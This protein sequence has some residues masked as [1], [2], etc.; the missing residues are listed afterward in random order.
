VLRAPGINCERETA[1]AFTRH[2]ASA[3]LLHVKRLLAEPDALDGFRIL[4]VPGGFAYGDH[5]AAGRI[6]AHELRT[7]LG[8]RL[9]RFVER[10]GLA[11]GICNGFQALAK[12]GL[13][14]RTTGPAALQEISLMHNDSDHYECRWV[15]L[16]CEASRCVFLTPGAVLEVPSAH[17]EGKYVPA[18]PELHA[19]LAA[20][21][22]VA[23]RY[24][25]AT[26]PARYPANPNGSLDD[27]A[28]ITDVTGRVL[29]LMPHPDRAFLPHHHPRWPREGLARPGDGNEI[30]RSMVRIARDEG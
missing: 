1:F 12:L 15:K 2:G 14:P 28:G 23:L 27:V 20:E 4:A 24:V 13:L 26:A 5:V 10:G 22:Y 30:F 6:L 18:T 8:D 19:L 16:R 29:G 9:V 17:G 21:G 11:I 25:G 7:G 3:E